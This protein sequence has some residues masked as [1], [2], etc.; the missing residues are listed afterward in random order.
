MS[1]SAGWKHLN[2][3]SASAV[4]LAGVGQ[5][6]QVILRRV[7]I[8]TAGAG[9]NTLTIYDSSDTSGTVVA[10]IDTTR[11]NVAGGEYD[12]TLTKGLAVVLNTGT[13]ADVTVIWD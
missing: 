2:A 13:A 5:T 8:N 10:V 7:T 3:N 6:A 11:G 12:I 4:A 9:G 1:S